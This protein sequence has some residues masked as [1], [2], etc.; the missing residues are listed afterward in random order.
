LVLWDWGVGSVAVHRDAMARGAVPGVAAQN[1]HA[2]LFA[3]MTLADE[4]NVAA[5][6]VAGTQRHLRA[7][8]S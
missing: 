2:R 5:V 1:L 6:Y 4:R 7:P 3:W 8:T